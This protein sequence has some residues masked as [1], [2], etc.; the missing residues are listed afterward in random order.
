MIFRAITICNM[1][2]YYGEQRFEFPDKPMDKN[3]IVIQG[4]NGDGK[5]S[6]INSVKLL[7]A[8]PIEDIRRTTVTSRDRMPNTKQYICG[9]QGFWG[10][11][12]QQAK[13]AKYQDTYE[14]WVNAVFDTE[15][16][17][18]IA[19]RRWLIK[20]DEYEEIV[21]VKTPL[22][23]KLNDQPAKNYL[24]GCLPNE[25]IS[26]FFFDG[27]DVRTL[28]EAN[29]NKTI[30]KM[31]LLL[32][33]RPLENMKQ[34]LK[35]LRN[36][37]TKIAQLTQQL[38]DKQYEKQELE[39]LLTDIKRQLRLVQGSPLQENAGLLKGQLSEQEETLNQ[40]LKNISATFQRD[41]FIRLCPSSLIDKCLE[42]CIYW[43]HSEIA[44]QSA[45]LQTLKDSLPEKLFE[46]PPP[47]ASDAI[48][49]LTETEIKFYTQR[50]YHSLDYYN[51][52]VNNPTLLQLDPS[53][54]RRLLKQM[55]IYQPDNNPTDI[56][57]KQLG[58][59]RQLKQ[60]IREVENKLT[61][62]GEISVEI[63][64]EYDRLIQEQEQA[65][66]TFREM[67][68]ALGEIINKKELE[69]REQKK[70]TH[71]LDLLQNEAAKASQVRAKYNLAGCL[72]NAL[73]EAKQRLKQQKRQDL[74]EYYN[75]HLKELLDSNQLIEKI[76]I[77]EHFHI[78]YYNQ[79]NELVQMGSISAGMEQ[80]AATALL[81][82]LKETS[83]KNIPM[84]VDT[85]LGRLDSQHQIN[86][87]TKYY[88]QVAEQI[89][90]LPT[91]SEL[92]E[93][94]RALLQQYIYC[95]YRLVNEQNGMQTTLEKVASNG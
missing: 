49:A 22:R 40:I 54:A 84:I 92:D 55:S 59:G 20:K 13:S 41:A 71:K 10:I 48:R 43:A 14:C 19:E 76:E 65:N 6:F 9:T 63:R 35:G 12:N 86:L 28:S 51:I 80:L 46:A 87:L 62:T 39:N 64:Q 23:G 69:E 30:S 11:L 94:K 47:Y 52:A 44:G 4:R 31:E 7:F 67:E 50:L 81:W 8:G 16:G 25:Y 93:R 1:F 78:T 88:P 5:T 73:D 18:I 90:I 77:D 3:I 72:I 53:Q 21:Y 75:L 74:E 89:I 33:I 37:W 70:Y 56:L 60:K 29:T 2:S 26:F 82:A 85:P 58:H 79:N 32:N 36:D 42:L 45:L 83:E 57:A 61:E 68:R 27:E 15:E 17:E 34:A 91:D 24:E 95:E 38:E 66:V